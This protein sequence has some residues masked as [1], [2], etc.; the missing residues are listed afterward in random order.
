MDVGWYDPPAGHVS[1]WGRPSFAPGERG[2]GDPAGS[3]RHVGTWTT[4][5]THD[6]WSLPVVHPK[7]LGKSRIRHFR[8][9]RTRDPRDLLRSHCE[10]ARASCTLLP[11]C[12]S[13][14]R[15]WTGGLPQLGDML[16]TPMTNSRTTRKIN[17]AS[18][19]Y[20][21]SG[22]GLADHSGC[23]TLPFAMVLLSRVIR[24]QQVCVSVG[25]RTQ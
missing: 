14:W 17:P 23:W 22:G 15:I 1:F 11:S 12:R 4:R 16:T 18:S 13:A 19:E 2:G 10:L 8:P 7:S 21:G 20:Q 24:F 5:T 6:L 9:F 3:I 25:G